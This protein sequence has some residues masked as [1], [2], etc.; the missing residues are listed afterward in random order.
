MRRTEGWPEVTIC[1]KFIALKSKWE[2]AY[3]VGVHLGLP[4][5][6]GL[7]F[8]SADP[9]VYDGDV[10]EYDNGEV[11]EYT[12]EVGLMLELFLRVGEVGL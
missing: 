8:L 4:E 10:G 1:K 6:G 5:P 3:E 11:G 2:R 7:I 9:G 12:G